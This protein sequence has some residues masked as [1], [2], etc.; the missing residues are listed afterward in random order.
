MT[1]GHAAAHEGTADHA[2]ASGEAQD[3]GGGATSGRTP[4]TPLKWKQFSVCGSCFTLPEYYEVIKGIGQGAYGTV[5]SATNTQTRSNV[6]VKKIGNAFSHAIE[7]PSIPPSHARP[8]R[9][10]IPVASA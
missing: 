4:P 3:S 9:I 2:A 10:W 7:V 8:R 5:C 1:D 6:A